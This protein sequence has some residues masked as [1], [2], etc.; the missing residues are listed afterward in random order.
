MALAISLHVLA[1]VIWVG[2]MFFAYMALRPVAATLLE[3]PVRLKLWEQVFNRF[4]SWV[5]IAIVVLLGTGSWMVFAGFGGMAKIGANVHLMIGLGVVM[6]MLFMHVYFG[7]FRRLQRAVAESNWQEGT[8]K[9]NQIRMFILITLVLGLLVV[10]AAGG[11]R[12]F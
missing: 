1:A 3:V 11:G 2:G 6:M 8:N 7:P 5:W 10:V 4:F 12:Y 9:L